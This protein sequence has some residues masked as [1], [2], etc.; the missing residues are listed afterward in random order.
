MPILCDYFSSLN[1][2]LLQY[3]H[4]S[5]LAMYQRV[6]DSPTRDQ[7]KDHCIDLSM[8]LSKKFLIDQE[9]ERCKII[10]IQTEANQR[11]L[12][13]IRIVFNS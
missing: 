9:N 3:L 7:L 1:P 12:S 4:I 13:G 2:Q 5:F 11:L 6:M 10:I 8:Q